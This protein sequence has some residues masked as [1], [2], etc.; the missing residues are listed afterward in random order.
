MSARLMGM[1]FKTG[2]P[3]GQRFVLVKLCDCANDDGLCYPSQ[4]TLAEDTGF[5]ETAVRQHIKW[6]KDN[7]FIKSARRQRGRERKS[8]IYRINVALLEKCYAEAAKRKAARQAKMW[9][10]P[11]DYEPSDFE[12]SDYEPSDFDAKNH[13]ILSGEPSD[14]ALRT[15]RFCAKNHQILSGE[16]S[17]F[18]GSLYVEPSVEPSGSNARGARPPAGPHPAKPQTAP[19]ETAPAAK[20]KKTGR[21]ET[22]LSLLADY[23]ITGQAAEDFLQ[24]RKAKRQPLTETAMRLIAADAEKCGMTALQAAEYAIA[25][26]WGSFRADWLQNKTFGRSGNRGGPTHNQTAAVPD[27]GSYG[28]MPTTDF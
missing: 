8:D 19:P 4:E 24:V 27:A 11:L 17:D 3:R 9:E 25:S 10:E 13:Q 5:A 23:G 1:A 16:P 12:P 14:F 20:A 2:I 6:L 18:D 28:D 15:V 26:G 7:N 22:E 21:H